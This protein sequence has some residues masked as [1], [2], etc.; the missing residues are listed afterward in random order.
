M[1][2]EY[3]AKRASSRLQA[4]RLFF[5]RPGWSER[6]CRAEI[7][8]GRRESQHK[9][10]A[11]RPEWDE[12][13]RRDVVCWSTRTLPPARQ[14]GDP[15]RARALVVLAA[16]TGL[17]RARVLG[18]VLVAFLGFWPGYRRWRADTRASCPTGS[19]LPVPGVHSDHAGGDRSSTCGE[20]NGFFAAGRPRAG[21]RLQ[22]LASDLCPGDA[23]PAGGDDRLAPASRSPS[24]GCWPPTSSRSAGPPSGR[25]RGP[26]RRSALARTLR[27]TARSSARQGSCGS[28]PPA[29]RRR[30]RGRPATC[31]RR[32]G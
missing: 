14:R 17:F 30:G 32:S 2:I 13:S 25:W 8:G 9:W 31:R 7:A 18:Q 20:A 26:R 5:M 16:L 6:V 27:A 12:T 4:P 1:N 10:S 23:D 19:C 3:A 21:R 29:H 22:W 11:L 24:T 15:A 28:G